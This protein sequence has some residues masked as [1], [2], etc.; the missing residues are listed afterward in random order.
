MIECPIMSVNSM[1]RENEKIKQHV[2]K[3]YAEVAKGNSCCEVPVS[4]CQNSE[5]SYPQKVGYSKEE[6]LGLPEPVVK[7]A[8]GCGAPIA[9][10]NL[11]EG[12]V[13]LDLGSGE[14][15]DAFL[16]ARKVGSKGK[17][18]GVDMT[19]EM[20]QLAEKNAEKMKA[21]NV[22]FLLGEIENLPLKDEAFDLV[23]SNCVVNLSPD[24]GLVFAEAFRVLKPGGRVL[25]S[26]IVTQ[27]ELPREIREDLR[28]WAA[29]ISGALSEAEY[30]QKVR[31]AGFE[32]VEV[33]IRKDF[34]E[35]VSSIQVRAYKPS[36]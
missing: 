36:T 14:G 24:K 3:F 5:T 28:M 12:E 29:C 22:E 26:D 17:V 23:I 9:L 33:V 11:Q 13:V 34:M 27:R 2:R 21:R 25:I 6:L 18:I 8:A 4:C 32:K 31:D 35:L 15:M 7:T 19:E 20:V 10:A 1:A 16:A 30:I